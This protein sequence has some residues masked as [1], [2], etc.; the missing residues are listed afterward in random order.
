MNV[1]LKAFAALFA[2]TTMS[3][4]AGAAIES[5]D[6]DKAV[7]VVASPLGLGDRG[8]RKERPAASET[9][10]RIV[11]LGV[12]DKSEASPLETGPY[13]QEGQ[14]TSQTRF[15]GQSTLSRYDFS[16]APLSV[17]RGRATGA[18]V[19]AVRYVDMRAG[20]ANANV[21][22]DN[23]LPPPATAAV[24]EPGNWAMILAGL[25]AAG[26]IARRRMSL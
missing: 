19:A 21:R 20:T 10:F 7:P 8:I 2:L 26:A 11:Q 24:P 16:Q 1:K 3:G 4:Q 25:L 15:R 13:A 18:A 22:G 5:C 9:G 17:R 14:Y 6:D 23:R 12:T